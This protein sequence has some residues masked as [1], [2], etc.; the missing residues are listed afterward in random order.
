M[1]LWNPCIQ[2]VLNNYQGL[3]GFVRG[4]ELVKDANLGCFLENSQHWAFVI[5]T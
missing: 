3:G 1:S 2:S 5:P 4:E